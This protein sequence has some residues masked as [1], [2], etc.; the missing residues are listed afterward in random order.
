MHKKT[1]KEGIKIWFGRFEGLA[2]CPLV[3]FEDEDIA[4]FV[5]KWAGALE[6]AARG[7]TPVAAQEAAREQEEL[8]AAVHRNTGVRRLAANPL[9][10]TILAPDETPG[11]CLAGAKV[12]ALPEIRG[13]AYGRSSSYPVPMIP[14]A[15][16]IYLQSTMNIFMGERIEEDIRRCYALDSP[17]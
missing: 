2:E 9:L 10:L 14:I 7:D 13:N 12:R 5:E 16:A 6:R 3:D 8:L 1:L 11:D 4:L 17:L 15:Q